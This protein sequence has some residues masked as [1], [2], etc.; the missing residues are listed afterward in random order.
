MRK[1]KNLDYRLFYALILISILSSFSVKS[2]I[3]NGGFEQW[4]STM[5]SLN[6]PARHWKFFA[7]FVGNCQSYPNGR[8]ASGIASAEAYKGELALMIEP[9]V[10]GNRFPGLVWI[11]TNHDTIAPYDKAIVIEDLPK[12][13]SFFY[14]YS[15]AENDTLNGHALVFHYNQATKTKDTLAFS[16][17][18]IIDAQ[19][20]YIEKKVEV[21][22]NNWPTGGE[23]FFQLKFETA[24]VLDTKFWL[25]EVSISK[26][27]TKLNNKL[28]SE[29]QW[30]VYPNP[31]KRY[32]TFKKD[33][34]IEKIELYNLQG[35]LV[36]SFPMDINS[37]IYKIDDVPKGYYII[38][39]Q[40]DGARFSTNL[41]T[42]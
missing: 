30:S 22:Y 13:V 14:K 26:T 9:F 31:A 39:F 7:P 21:L 42:D 2:Q 5:A 24:K 12:E 8:I 36:K 35:K 19:P 17:F 38:Q 34:G 41:V 3:K 10:C 25:D 6:L 23:V 11:S 32:F 28:D 33:K 16:H 18:T 1:L 4:D 20:D 15:P 40:K 29:N 27:Y 37:D